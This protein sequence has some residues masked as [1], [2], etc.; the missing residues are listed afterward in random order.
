MSATQQQIAEVLGVSRQ[1][2][3]F[4][5]NGGGTLSQE[6]RAH[7]IKAAAEM[8]YRPNHSARAMRS[9]RFDSIGL[10]LGTHEDTTYLPWGLFVEIL[11]ESTLHDVHV[12]VTRM[13]DEKLSDPEF[14]PKI[15][16][17][18]M[19]D[20]LLIDYI[21]DV[22]KHLVNVIEQ[23]HIPSIWINSQ[24]ENDCVYPDDYRGA[25]EATRYLLELGHR[26]IAYVEQQHNM[27]YSAADRRRGY[28]Q[29]MDEAK[30]E[31]DV[32]SMVSAYGG[33]EAL[34][35]R[36]L[37]SWLRSEKRPT[38]VFAYEAYYAMPVLAAAMRIGLR[39]PEELSLIGVHHETIASP[40]FGIT[41]MMLPVYEMG[42]TAVKMLLQKIAQPQLPL[43]P[44]VL[45]LSL[46][47]GRTCAPPEHL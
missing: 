36:Q 35:A 13:P 47:E 14:V 42:S 23:H 25:Y 15:M 26:R 2:V 4:A 45:S 27:H 1:A 7:I 5:L 3:S 46:D 11:S 6:T 37:E 43:E 40:G 44:C 33:E 41:T 39:V 19:V 31:P 28:E 32:L 30:L 38:A 9:G 8:G 22:P 34:L 10:L 24:R 16:R 21:F 17:E 20:G 29:A 12:N 18:L